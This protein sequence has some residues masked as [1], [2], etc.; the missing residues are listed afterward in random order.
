MNQIIKS[1]SPTFQQISDK[2]IEQLQDSNFDF[3]KTLSTMHDLKE[4]LYQDFELWL[5]ENGI[6]QAEFHDFISDQNNFSQEE[7]NKIKQLVRQITSIYESSLLPLSP[8]KKKEASLKQLESQIQKNV[9]L[10]KI[11]AVEVTPRTSPK[12]SAKMTTRR[13]WLPIK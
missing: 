9:P 10:N 8:S 7:Q 1:T 3:Q 2:L 12:K 13:Q 5:K 4:K 6:S 11:L